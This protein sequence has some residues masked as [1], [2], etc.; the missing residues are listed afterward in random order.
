MCVLAPVSMSGPI[1]RVGGQSSHLDREPAGRHVN[2]VDG[3]GI[4]AVV[5]VVFFVCVCVRVCVWGAST[6]RI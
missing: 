2:W 4:V 5:F 3:C 6:R 1:D